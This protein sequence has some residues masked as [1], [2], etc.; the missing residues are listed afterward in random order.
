MLTASCPL[1]PERSKDRANYIV[2]HPAAGLKQRRPIDLLATAVGM[3]IVE[4]F[5]ERVEAYAYHGLVKPAFAEP[6]EIESDLR[7]SEASGCHSVRPA[8]V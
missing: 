3:E 1:R 2:G 7:R 5:L 8:D 6:I 4:E